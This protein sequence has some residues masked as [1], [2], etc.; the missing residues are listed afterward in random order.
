MYIQ[1]GGYAPKFMHPSSPFQE[2][3]GI[4]DS[5]IDKEKGS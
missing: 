1:F 4:P 3:V 2:L 5:C